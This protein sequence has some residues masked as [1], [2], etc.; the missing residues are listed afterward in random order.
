MLKQ[1]KTDK[2]YCST[3]IKQ[4]FSS[5]FNPY[6]GFLKMLIFGLC[7][8]LYFFKLSAGIGFWYIAILLGKY[9]VTLIRFPP[10]ERVCMKPRSEIDACSVVEE[11]NFAHATT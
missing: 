11:R 5:C 8:V 7:F 2:I 4:S 10:E 1:F 9:V 3:N 6:L